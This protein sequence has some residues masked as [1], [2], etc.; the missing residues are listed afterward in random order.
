[1]NVT[2]SGDS[3]VVEGSNLVLNC[4]ADGDPEPTY[5]WLRSGSALP[6]KVDNPSSPQL[7]IPDMTWADVGVYYCLA[8]NSG[9]VSYSP[10]VYVL[11]QAEEGAIISYRRGEQSVTSTHTHTKYTV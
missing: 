1:M 7:V 5:Q 9:G 10:A 2:V 11:L 8:V 6:A 3:A 4:S